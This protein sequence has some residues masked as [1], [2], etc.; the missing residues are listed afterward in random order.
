MQ[1][2]GL[3]NQGLAAYGGGATSTIMHPVAAV[4]MCIGVVC[5]LVLPRKYA[6]AAFLSV[7]LLLPP[8]QEL[9]L[10]GVHVYAFRILILAG[11]GRMLWSKFLGKGRICAGGV[12]V[13]DKVF[14]GWAIFHAIA[15]ILLNGG[16]SGAIINQVGFLWD[17]IG[18]FFLLRFLIQDE[19]SVTTVIKTIAGLIFVISM[20]MLYEKF[21]DLNIYGYLGST[22][23]LPDIREGAIR[24][25]GPFAHAILAGVFGATM[26]PLCFWLWH[27][28]KS[29]LAAVGGVIGCLIMVVTAASSTSLLACG[30][31]L[32]GCC[33]WVLRKHMRAIRWGIVAVLVGLEIVMKAPVWFVIS[34]VNIVPGNSSYHRAMLIDMFVRHIG[35]WWLVGTNDAKNWGWDMWDLS[36]QFVDEGESGGLATFVCFILLVSWSFGLIGKARKAVEG[37]RKKEWFYW[38]LGVALFAHVMGFFGISYFDQ[39]KFTWYAFL[40]IIAV[41][42]SWVLA[43]KHAEETPAVELTHPATTISSPGY[44]H[45]RR[46]E[47]EVRGRL[48]PGPSYARK[49]KET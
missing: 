35:D 7:V 38:F 6:V 26:L 27:S 19:E 8:G 39:T 41:S 23:L 36:N 42:T 13:I 34:H 28:R 9:Y 21:H 32:L 43:P 15:G 47:V 18:A 29:R 11:W 22:T 10:A 46:P 5:L 1:T 49:L 33:M 25:R 20:T 44:A 48:K 12:T 2:E 24:A 14:L 3:Y 45:A 4:A 16:A 37:D 17:A 30:A 31:V 40:A